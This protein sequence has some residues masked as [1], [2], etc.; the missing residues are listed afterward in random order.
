MK[1]NKVFNGLREAASQGK[2]R[3]FWMGVL[4][5]LLICILAGCPETPVVDGKTME[6]AIALVVNRGEVGEL[7]EHEAY[8]YE[9]TA[10]A[11][12][13]YIHV[14]LTT[15]SILYVQLHDSDGKE[16]GGLYTYQQGSNTYRQLTISK[17]KKYYLKV[18][19]SDSGFYK[20]TFT[21]SADLTP[22]IAAE[23]ASAMPLDVDTWKRN[24]IAIGE[25]H[26][27][28]FTATADTQYIH[29]VYGTLRDLYVQVYESD[30]KKLGDSYNFS[31][32][33]EYVS[34]LPDS[35]KVYYLK[36][37]PYSSYDSGTYKIAFNTS[38]TPPSD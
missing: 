4:S 26:W 8:W 3:G 24:E 1:K 30:G 14:E 32:Y 31:Q 16:I 6:S 37:W 25:A 5:G 2:G 36:V 19:T 15:V 17:G 12:T 35:G 22:N 21:E 7:D 34:L 9:F 33:I 13:Q 29:I 27:Y 20:I 38:R 18:W 11:N 23:M 10:T 28:R